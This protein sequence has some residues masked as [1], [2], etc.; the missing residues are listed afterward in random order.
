MKFCKTLIKY[1]GK[2]FLYKP[3]SESANILEAQYIDD[4]NYM[5]EG[6]ISSPS[7][8]FST[9]DGETCHCCE[10]IIIDYFED[11]IDESF[12]PIY[13]SVSGFIKD[14]PI[15]SIFL[16][17]ISNSQPNWE[18]IHQGNGKHIERSLYGFK[19]NLKL[20]EQW[21]PD[22]QCDG[23]YWLLDYMLPNEQVKIINK[24]KKKDYK[25]ICDMSYISKCQC[26]GTIAA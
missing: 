15:G 9:H 8:A 24:K 11:E 19:N 7:K 12:K 18:I 20:T 3:N 13:T 14:K 5:M 10:A 16:F 2:P 26:R 6:F 21:S 25:C 22:Y 1:K 4:K 17:G 23:S